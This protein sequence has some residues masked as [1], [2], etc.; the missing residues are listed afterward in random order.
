MWKLIPP[1]NKNT[2]NTHKNIRTLEHALDHELALQMVH[3]IVKF[4]QRK[5]LKQHIH[6]NTYLKKKYKKWLWKRV[7]QFDE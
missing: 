3:R 2:H 5:S 6:M 4:N 1:L 7:F